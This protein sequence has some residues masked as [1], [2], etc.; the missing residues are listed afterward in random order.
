MFGHSQ[1]NGI[2]TQTRR[3]DNLPASL[4][5]MKILMP[6]NN[7]PQTYPRVENMLVITNKERRWGENPGPKRNNAPDPK[8]LGRCSQAEPGGREIGISRFRAGEFRPLE[9]LSDHP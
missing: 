9:V 2:T 1:K 7:Y 5:S 3:L 6:K 8:V 4:L